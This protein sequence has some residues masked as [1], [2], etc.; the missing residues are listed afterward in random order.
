M[1]D[2]E[3]A[4]RENAKKES[5]REY[6]KEDNGLGRVKES[7][8]EESIYLSSAESRFSNEELAR[9]KK[10]EDRVERKSRGRKGRGRGIVIRRRNEK[11]RKRQSRSRSKSSEV[12]TDGSVNSRSSEDVN[13][14]GSVISGTWHEHVYAAPPR[15]PTA[16]M[17]SDILGWTKRDRV[18]GASRADREAASI[19]NDQQMILNVERLG[20]YCSPTR[21]SFPSGT[22]EQTSSSSRLPTSCSSPDDRAVIRPEEFCQT[23]QSPRP[24]SSVSSCSIGPSESTAKFSPFGEDPTKHSSSPAAIPSLED[25]QFNCKTSPNKLLDDLPLNLSVTSRSQTEGPPRR[26]KASR[27]RP[28]ESQFEIGNEDKAHQCPSDNLHESIN[29]GEAGADARDN[30][31]LSKAQGISS[32]PGTI[33]KGSSFSIIKQTATE[34]MQNFRKNLVAECS[35]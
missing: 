31:D 6:E 18:P 19:V 32:V 5:S 15:V 21:S 25:S 26:P 23:S 33:L 28:T 22:I 1:D 27:A 2:T 17:I 29:D 34:I 16:H 20:A 10:E 4:E 35:K 3:L 30:G 11:E 8:G 9:D 12:S 13:S 14:D 24:K 7:R